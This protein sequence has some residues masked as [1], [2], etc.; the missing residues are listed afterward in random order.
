MGLMVRSWCPLSESRSSFVRESDRKD[1]PW[2]IVSRAFSTL[3]ILVFELTADSNGRP[4][5][6]VRLLFPRPLNR[7]KVAQSQAF[8]YLLLD[9]HFHLHALSRRVR[10]SAT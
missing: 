8:Q 4:F 5:Q 7:P 1:C 6:D 3:P 9:L 10:N 2:L